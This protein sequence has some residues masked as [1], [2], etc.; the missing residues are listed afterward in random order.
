M[1]NNVGVAMDSRGVPI[2]FGLMNISKKMNSEIKSSDYVG[3][4]QL[5]IQ[6]YHVGQTVGIFT[7]VE[8]KKQNWAFKGSP[9]ELAQEKF[10]NLVRA[11]GGY[12]G[13]AT[14]YDDYLK[15]IGKLK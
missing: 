4:T 10:I 13:F 6:P 14:T 11:W 9:H 3:I 1:R 15:I 5:L 8:F 12:A 7:G 2:R